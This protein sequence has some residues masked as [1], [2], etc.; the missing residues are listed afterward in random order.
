M[1]SKAPQ[2]VAGGWVSTPVLPLPSRVTS[3]LPLM[4]ALSTQSDGV[5]KCRV[6]KPPLSGP[7]RG[8]KQSEGAVGVTLAICGVLGGMDTVTGMPG[9]TVG[10][11]Q[12]AG[13][14][15]QCLAY[16]SPGI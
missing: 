3:A 1:G 15:G 6:K 4:M 10:A 9:P 2:I 8:P 13:G 5:R 16:A 12:Q 11:I 14:P 7:P